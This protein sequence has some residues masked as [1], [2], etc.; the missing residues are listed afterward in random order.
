[1][2]DASQKRSAKPVGARSPDRAPESDRRSPPFS[3]EETFGHAGGT[4]RR[5]CPNRAPH[6]GGTVRR[7]CP[8]RAPGSPQ[9]RSQSEAHFGSCQTII[10]PSSLPETTCPRPTNAARVTLLVCSLWLCSALPDFRSQT[11]TVLSAPLETRRDPSADTATL[12]TTPSWPWSDRVTLPV[13]MSHTRIA[14]LSPET[15]LLPSGRKATAI[16][17]PLLPAN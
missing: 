2:S 12:V 4:V 15:K 9:Q 3:E 16:T 8:N 1:M 13:A 7:P 11:R 14:P 6:A 10:M 5:P 17:A